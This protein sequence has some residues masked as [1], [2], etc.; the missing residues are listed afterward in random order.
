[1]TYVHS[2]CKPLIGLLGGVWSVQCVIWCPDEFLLRVWEGF[3][4]YLVSALLRGGNRQSC[5]PRRISGMW[6]NGKACRLCTSKACDL[7]AAPTSCVCLVALIFVAT[8]RRAVEASLSR[9]VHI[10]FSVCWFKQLLLLLKAQAPPS[11][12]PAHKHEHIRMAFCVTPPSV[13]L[14]WCPCVVWRLVQQAQGT[15]GSKAH[16][17]WRQ[18]GSRLGGPALFTVPGWARL[19]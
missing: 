16:C 2:L 3:R 8:L 15:A 1:M 12:P 6:S 10:K 19:V 17:N 9:C 11:T 18:N 7:T 5:H 14:H 4:N 13:G